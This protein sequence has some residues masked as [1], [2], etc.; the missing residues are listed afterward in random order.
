MVRRAEASAQVWVT[1]MNALVEHAD[2]LFLDM[3]PP[4]DAAPYEVVSVALEQSGTELHVGIAGGPG[5]HGWMKM[6]ED[7]HPKKLYEW[8]P[9]WFQLHL[10][11]GRSDTRG[12]FPTTTWRPV[13]P[14]Q[15]RRSLAAHPVF[16][17]P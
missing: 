7:E 12:F 8:L 13:Y 3:P 1:W 4:A 2:D 6:F 15:Q 14:E 11:L 10:D 16:R 17:R 9:L 5:T